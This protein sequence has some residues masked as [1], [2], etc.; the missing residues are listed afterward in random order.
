[1]DFLI[2]IVFSLYFLYKILIISTVSSLVSFFKILAL[3]LEECLLLI[4]K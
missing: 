2:I 4:Y 1:M 3:I